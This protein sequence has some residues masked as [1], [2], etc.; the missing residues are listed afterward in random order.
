MGVL[1]KEGSN[2][3]NPRTATRDQAGADL[4][5]LGSGPERIPVGP[6]NALIAKFANA[7]GVPV[8]LALRQAAQESDN[9]APDVVSGKRKSPAGASGLFQFMDAT[10]Q[11]LGKLL[12]LNPTAIKTDPTA[13]AQ[14]GTWYMGQLYKKFGDWKTAAWAYNWGEG[15]VTSYL[16]GKPITI[17]GKKVVRT[18]LPEETRLYGLIVAD[19]Y[20]PAQAKA[21]PRTVL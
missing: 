19:G 5:I 13:A 14:A 18:S 1:L 6:F 7:N 9:F 10:A 2:V 17:K 4:P 3:V 21:L 20:T 15:N 16:T 12:G 11:S 8:G